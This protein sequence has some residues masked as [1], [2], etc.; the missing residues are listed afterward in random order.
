M[1]LELIF[2]ALA[3]GLKK[4]LSD[5]HVS[6]DETKLA[7]FQKDADAIVRLN[8]RGLVN[9]SSATAMRRKLMKR[10]VH[11]ASDRTP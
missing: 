7:H 11:I 3:E 10:I 5:A 4:Q 9:D 6:I 2:G 8:I 1:K